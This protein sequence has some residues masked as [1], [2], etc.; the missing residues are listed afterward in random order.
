MVGVL[1]EIVALN[2]PGG[3][4]E[5]LEGRA[6]D[7]ELPGGGK[8]DIIISEWMGFYLLHESMLDSVILARQKH[9]QEDGIMFPSHAR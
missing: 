8:V 1:R 5:V 2:D 4:V 9:L 6:E 7:L 3:V